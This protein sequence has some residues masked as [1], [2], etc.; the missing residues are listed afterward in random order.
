MYNTETKKFPETMS[1]ICKKELN[2]LAI[3]CI[4]SRMK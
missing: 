2:F 4:A 1:S 3:N